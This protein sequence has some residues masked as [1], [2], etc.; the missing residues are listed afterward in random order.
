MIIQLI[1]YINGL[2]I[3]WTVLGMV[4]AAIYAEKI[5]NLPDEINAGNTPATQPSSSPNSELLLIDKL[6]SESD[7]KS[8]IN[9]GKTISA[10]LEDKYNNQD[11]LTLY[12]ICLSLVSHDF[13]DGLDGEKIRI[14]ACD[15]FAISALHSIKHSEIK[16]P[17][18]LQF[19]FLSLLALPQTAS[20]ATTPMTEKEFIAFREERAEYWMYGWEDLKTGIDP[21]F[22]FSNWPYARVPVPGGRYPPGIEPEAIS[23]LKIRVAYEREIRKNSLL[24]KKRNEQLELNQLKQHYIYKISKYIVYLYKCK[25]ADIEALKAHLIKLNDEELTKIVMEEWNKR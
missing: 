5:T 22:D 3:G 25:P 21:T 1:K 10:R 14:K 9:I 2:F 18:K 6:T 16:P 15:M 17:I 11:A 12:R 13:N 19:N 7:F 4:H 8:L 24:I 20:V 23:D